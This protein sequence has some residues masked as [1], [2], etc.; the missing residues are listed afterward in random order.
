MRRHRC[1]HRVQVALPV[2][3]V[4]ARLP[5]VAQFVRG[6]VGELLPAP[7]DEH[8]RA[9]RVGHPDQRRREVGHG[10]EARLGLPTRAAQLQVRSGAGE[11]FLRGERLDEVVVGSGGQALDRRL[12]PGPGRQQQHRDAGGPRIG[13]QCGEE[14]HPAQTRHHHVAHDEIGRLGTDRRQRR[15]T[16]AHHL[17]GVAR[18]QQAGQVLAHV[19]VV[20]GDQHPALRRGGRDR[21]A[22]LLGVGT[23]QPA[24]R[25]GDERLGR[26]RHADGAG[27]RRRGHHLVRRQ[28]LVAQRERDRERGAPAG[29]ALD[30]DRAAVQADQLPDDRQ[31]DP[32]ALAR[33]R[34]GPLHPV[35]ALE[36]A[37]KLVG[38]HPGSGVGDRQHRGPLVPAQGDGDPALERELDGVG[39]QVEDDLLPHVPVDVHRLGQAGDVHLVVE[40]RPLHRRAEDA[41]QFRGV[42]AQ[43]D[44][45]ET[46]V[47]PA[48]LEPREVQQ[49]V[50]QLAEP[51]CVAVDEV[52]LLA[53]PRVRRDDRRAAQLG[54]RPHDQGQRGAEL[55]ADVGEEVGLGPVQLRQRLGPLPLGLVGQRVGDRGRELVGHQVEERPVVGVERAVRV[56]PGDEHPGGLRPSR[57]DERQDHRVGRERRARGP[58]VD[59][60]CGAVRQ[61][62]DDLGG[63]GVGDPPHRPAV[64]RPADDGRRG[65]A[66]GPHSAR[67]HQ[68]QAPVRR[69]QVGRRER[70]VLPVPRQ[71]VDDR[72]ARLLR[73]AGGHRR[74][75]SEV[76]QHAEPPLA[77]DPQRGVGD[78]DED[79][80]DAA[81]LV[82]DRRVGEGPVRL[83]QVAVPAEEQQL[84]VGVRGAPARQHRPGHRAE[85]GPG[86]RPD[87]RRGPPQGVRVLVAHR[88]D[89]RVVVEDGQVRAP[90]HVHREPRR[91]T[92]GQGGLEALRPARGRTHRCARPV[93]GAHALRHPT[94]VRAGRRPGRLPRHVAHP[95]TPASLPDRV[96]RILAARATQR[97][98]WCT[99]GAV[100]SRRIGRTMRPSVADAFRSAR[101]TDRPS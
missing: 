55:V 84:V 71:H 18:A 31:T 93:A 9:A 11:Q 100:R 99:S 30:V 10:G 46:R 35:E 82:L 65:R 86:L 14:L 3:R 92:D 34:R 88:R 56:H 54:D 4:Q 52:E 69:A 38:G 75:L 74:E 45:L 41:R 32:A 83:L 36:E 1:G 81:A 2:L 89:V 53:Q 6:T 28:V 29:G 12:L 25:L 20:V 48:R 98:S 21:G 47:H 44:G 68:L 7:V 16:V 40:A 59:I 62:P 58:G 66:P 101:R 24:Q 42:R 95:L 19:G 87:L 60:A 85:L 49:G 50:D 43:V 67:G 33:T 79:P 15:G 51:E 23:L 72:P 77:D 78:R 13:A 73:R 39:Q 27:L 26:R 94:G 61:V 76:A 91:Q 97:D 17:H 64:G 57:D 96:S 5:A 70:H 8:P 63:G 80:A 37:G 90:P 22:A